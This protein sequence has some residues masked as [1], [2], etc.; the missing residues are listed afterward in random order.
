MLKLSMTEGTALTVSHGRVICSI[1]SPLSLNDPTVYAD[2]VAAMDALQKKVQT[3]MPACEYKPIPQDQN[4]INKYFEK[5]T[6][7][8]NLEQELSIATSTQ[9]LKIRE[10]MLPDKCPDELQ[11]K[12]WANNVP[13]KVSEMLNT[14]RCRMCSVGSIRRGLAGAGLGNALQMLDEHI[15]KSG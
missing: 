10:H 2:A 12:I 8:F 5:G 6:L 11:F 14:F 1:M 7:V 4:P 13:G 15:A 9:I 3:Y